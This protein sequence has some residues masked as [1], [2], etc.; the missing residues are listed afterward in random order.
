MVIVVREKKQGNGENVVGQLVHS[1]NRG[2]RFGGAGGLQGDANITW[3][4]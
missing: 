4:G 1:D 3:G 2:L